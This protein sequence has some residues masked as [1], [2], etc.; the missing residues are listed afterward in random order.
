MAQ[1]S[2][3]FDFNFTKRW[4]TLLHFYSENKLLKILMTNIW[5]FFVTGNSYFASMS[6]ISNLFPP[7]L[8]TMFCVPQI[9]NIF[10]VCIDC[11]KQWK[12]IFLK[13]NLKCF[14]SF[15]SNVRWPS[16]VFET[17][18]RCFYNSMS[19]MSD[20]KLVG[21]SC[22]IM[23]QIMPCWQMFSSYLDFPS[24]WIIAYLKIVLEHFC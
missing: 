12:S 5:P 24:N 17:P 18:D 9:E 23:H 21:K 10:A 8:C 7:K 19:N 1:T 11:Q 6:G 20:S 3:Q 16:H 13:L 2:N 14:W 22:Q 4:R 15:K